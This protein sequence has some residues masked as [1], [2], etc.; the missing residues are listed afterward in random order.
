MNSY[1]RISLSRICCQNAITDVTIKAPETIG[2]I[3]P[4]NSEKLPFIQVLAK[5]KKPIRILT[6]ATLRMK[7]D[8]FF[9]NIL[10]FSNS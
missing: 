6:A 10:K 4:G 3:Q 8:I 9:A 1:F 5:S 2:I 7:K